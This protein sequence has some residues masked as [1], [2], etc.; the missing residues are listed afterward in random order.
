LPYLWSETEARNGL[1]GGRVGV[2]LRLQIFQVEGK[3]QN[4]DFSILFSGIQV[5]QLSGCLF[6][7]V[8]FMERHMVATTLGSTYLGSLSRSIG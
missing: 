2:K 3:F 8:V 5:L 7:V 4:I 6:R 1:V